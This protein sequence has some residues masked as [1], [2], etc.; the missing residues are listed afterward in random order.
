MSRCCSVACVTA[1]G[2]YGEEEDWGEEEEEEKGARE[3]R[4][5]KAHHSPAAVAVFQGGEEGRGGYAGCLVCGRWR[6]RS[7]IFFCYAASVEI[8]E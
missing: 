2:T 8:S 7:V 1:R 5:K 3:E 4:K 6:E